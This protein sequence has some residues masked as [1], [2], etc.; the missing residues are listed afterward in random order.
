MF[1]GYEDDC[2]DRS[3]SKAE[4]KQVWLE[5]ISITMGGGQMPTNPTTIG[6]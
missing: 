3:L 5:F 6:S 1:D 4:D 2:G